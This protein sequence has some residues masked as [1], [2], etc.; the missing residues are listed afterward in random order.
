MFRLSILAIYFSTCHLIAEEFGDKRDKPGEVQKLRVP[1]ELIPPSTPRSPEEELK[2][3]QVAPGFKIELVACEPLV[4]DPVVTQIAPDGRLWV[5][6][7]RGFMAAMDGKGEE[8]PVGRVVVLE[9]TDHDGCMDK[10]TVFLDG[11]VMPRALMLVGDGALVGAPPKLWFCRDTDDDGKA[12]E[13]IEIAGEFGWVNNPLHPE[14]GNPEQAANSLLWA[15]DNWIYAAHY[16][17]K[18]RFEG[19]KFYAGVTTFRGQWGLAQDD[20]GHLFYNSNQD[21]LRVDIL[22]SS[23]TG[24]NPNYEPCGGT[25]IQVYADQ[26]VW[27]IRVNPGV[28]RGYRDGILREN[29]HLKEFTAACSPHIYRGGAFGPE[30][31]GNPFI[32]EPGGNLIK[33]EIMTAKNGTLT[34]TEAY[35]Q[36]EFVASTDERFRPVNLTTGPDGALYITDFYR[37]VLQHR[38][39]FT[40]YL[41]SYSEQRGLDKPTHLG[42]IWRVAPEN[43][44]PFA[45]LDLKKE[46]SAQLIEHLASKN[47]WWRETAQRLLVERNDLSVVPLLKELIASGKTDMAKVHALWTL[48]GLHQL[49]EATATSALIDQGPRVR[50]TAIRLCESFFKTDARGRVIN[51]L[52]SMT[53]ERDPLVQQQLALTLGEA[54]DHQADLAMAV[55]VQQ[56]PST[57]FLIDAV[58]SGL[59]GREASLLESLVADASSNDKLIAT[60]ARCVV[61]SRKAIDIEK[62]IAWIAS[63]K[64]SSALLDGATGAS[65]RK[66]VKL[67]NEPTALKRITDKCVAKLSSLLVWPDK[68]GVK[69]E[70]PLVPLTKEQQTRY[71][72]GKVLF[73]GVCAACHQTHGKGLDGVAP[74][75]MDSEWVLGP[76]QRIVRIVLHGLTGPVSVKGKTYRLDMPA[77]ASFTDDQIAGILTYIRREWEHNAAPVGPDTVKAIRT[78]TANRHEAWVSQQLQ[79]FK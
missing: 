21:P 24:R 66:P 51:K 40:S 58:V 39:S 55:L 48:D 16:T 6:E 61:A 42:R 33:R 7:M 12:D 26:L 60:L 69:P 27:P 59:G 2:S 75:L 78:A 44:K 10:S 64:K 70:P 57:E 43:V 18:Y 62:L 67:T 9:D 52:I 35:D 25:N 56:A 14:L 8:L 46:P 20:D 74:P 45:S 68:P 23:Y 41:R 1:E 65:L 15:F 3:F 71:D 32:C 5:V 11:L 28:N 34:C 19:G 79:E 31:E 30:F 50:A 63:S 22:P 38:E 77:F 72:L 17:R 53:S 37:G 29:G 13:K 47:N 4:Q 36:N 76:E 73:T 49:D 54:S